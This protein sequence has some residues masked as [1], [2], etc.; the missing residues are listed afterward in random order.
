M[1]SEPAAIMPQQDWEV[2]M[3]DEAAQEGFFHYEVRR[4]EEAYRLP[5]LRNWKLV[6]SAF[7]TMNVREHRVTPIQELYE[8]EA[9]LR[10]SVKLKPEDVLIC[11][12]PKSGT[13]LV[14]QIVLLLLNSGDHEALDPLSKNAIRPTKATFGKIWPEACLVPD[15]CTER[16][17]FRPIGE[18]FRPVE[19]SLFE[20]MH[21]PRVIKTHNAPQHVVGCDASGQLAESRYIIVCRNPLDTCVSAYYHGWSPAESGVPF[22]AW[23][24]AWLA[25]LPA[26]GGT[27]W[28]YYEQWRR[29]EQL[30]TKRAQFLWVQYEHIKD[31]PEREIRRIAAFL[32][33]DGDDALIARVVHGSDFT[34][35]KRS[36][37]EAAKARHRLDSDAH[38]R[39]GIVGDHINHFEPERR[40]RFISA[41]QGGGN[42]HAPFTDAVSLSFNSPA[43]QVSPQP[44]AILDFMATLLLPATMNAANTCIIPIA[45]AVV[46]SRR[47]SAD[48][49]RTEVLHASALEIAV[50]T[51]GILLST[52][53]YFAMP[54]RWHEG[55]TIYLFASGCFTVGTGAYMTAKRS[56]LM[57]CVTTS[58]LVGTQHGVPGKASKNLLACQTPKRRRKSIHSP[59]RRRLQ[60]RLQKRASLLI[61]FFIFS[62]WLALAGALRSHASQVICHGVQWLAAGR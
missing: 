46:R 26:Q 6:G 8:H 48:A 14:E 22:D 9:W 12:Y 44:F 47:M 59:W 39:K 31:Q 54:S 42:P 58:A 21:S 35:M 1:E 24:V 13:T 43:E 57:L 36:A 41:L 38:M 30:S 29:A 28:T 45:E 37:K 5:V 23:S 61:K 56:F 19:L 53:A 4:G 16:A 32:G 55:R 50:S 25:G 7:Y 27:W 3:V 40:R 2:V 10:M 15:G 34:V 49:T 51:A 17:P 20:A 60:K 62:L 52:L 11:S 18:Q 33:I